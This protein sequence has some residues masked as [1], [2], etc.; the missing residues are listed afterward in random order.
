MKIIRGLF[1]GETVN[2]EGRFFKVHD[3]KVTLPPTPHIPIY[4]AFPAPHTT[5]AWQKPHRLGRLLLAQRLLAFNLGQQQF[6]PA[7]SAVDVAGPQFGRDAVA[8]TVEQQQRMITSGLEVPVVGALLLLA[9]E[10]KPLPRIVLW[11]VV[12]LAVAT[13]GL[14]TSLSRAHY[15]GAFRLTVPPFHTVGLQRRR[16]RDCCSVAVTLA[17]VTGQGRS[18]LD[19]HQDIFRAAS[20]ICGR[21]PRSVNH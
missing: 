21:I 7:V 11:Q 18:S 16:D 6:F 13:L 3:L 14:G 8:F 2:L 15:R 12:A 5:P 1:A 19:G 17:E 4:L 20:E 10:K 9:I